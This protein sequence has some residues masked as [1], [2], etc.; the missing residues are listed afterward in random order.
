[1]MS[2]SAF[3]SGGRTGSGL[4]ES[5]PGLPDEPH[6][7]IDP[8]ELLSLLGEDYTHDILAMTREEAVP[9]REIADRLD[10]SRPTVYRR[11]NSL[12]EAG[13]VDT[14]LALHSEG[15]HRQQFRATVD[16]VSLSFE[17]GEITVAD[18]S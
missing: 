10:I 9:A 14:S 3:G 13:L 16:E 11:L 5:G 12:Q 8:E 2:K 1:M 18:A 15:H 7:P 17:D 6:P 4:P